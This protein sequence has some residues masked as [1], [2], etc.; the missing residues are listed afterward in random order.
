[1]QR[2]TVVFLSLFLAVTLDAQ[3]QRAVGRPNPAP[4]VTPEAGAP[5]PGL[6]TTQRSDYTEAL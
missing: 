1:M 6:T 2:A 5:L 4:D 3:R